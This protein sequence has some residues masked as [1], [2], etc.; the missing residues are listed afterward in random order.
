MVGIQSFTRP[1]SYILANK[2]RDLN[3]DLKKWNE[4]VGKVEMTLNDL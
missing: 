2:L 3:M 1:P 4:E